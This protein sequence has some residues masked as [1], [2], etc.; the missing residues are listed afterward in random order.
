MR[1]I[2]QEIRCSVLSAS[3]VA[4]GL[5][6][7]GSARAAEP[8]FSYSGDNGPGFWSELSSEWGACAG[9]AQNAR[10]SPINI[11]HARFDRNLRPLALQ[12]Y[13]TTVDIFNNGHTIEQ[14]YEGTGSVIRFEEDTLSSCSSTS[15]RCPSTPLT[16]TAA[17][18]NC[19]R[20]LKN[21]LVGTNW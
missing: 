11:S 1:S 21:R 14:N 3:I 6:F 9:T 16:E 15:I 13:P 12:S 8:E 2:R 20:Y 10:Q 4:V 18:W 7:G 19:M 17:P 5:C